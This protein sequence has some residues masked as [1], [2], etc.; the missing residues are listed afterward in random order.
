MIDPSSSTVDEVRAYLDKHPDD[1]EAVK[2]AESDGKARVGILGYEPTGPVA[3]E[4]ALP[5]HAVVLE[6]T[7]TGQWERL[8]ED[9]EPVTV[10]GKEV[11]VKRPK[12]RT[13]LAGASVAEVT[14]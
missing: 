7:P 5:E 1:L 10:G 12:P 8:V 6:D 14:A 11:Q 13:D 3:E 4:A 9:G 2:A